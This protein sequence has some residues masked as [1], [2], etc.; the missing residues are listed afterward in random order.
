MLQRK[1]REF[2]ATLEHFQSDI[3]SLESE[4]GELREKLMT[5]SKRTLLEGIARGI[6]TIIGS[7]G[8]VLLGNLYISYTSLIAVLV[9]CTYVPY[10]M[11]LH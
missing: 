10:D 1:E 9:Y 6:T 7:F 8:T 4:K 3:E 2:E 11:G 5:A